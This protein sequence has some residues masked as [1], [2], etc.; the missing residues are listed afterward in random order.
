MRPPPGV[1][2]ESYEHVSLGNNSNWSF[3]FVKQLPGCRNFKDSAWRDILLVCLKYNGSY[4]CISWWKRR[5][6]SLICTL[7]PAYYR[8]LLKFAPAQYTV[9]TFQLHKNDYSHTLLRFNPTVKAKHF[10]FPKLDGIVLWKG[11]VTEEA[12]FSMIYHYIWFL[13]LFFCQIIN[14]WGC[15][16]VR[17]IWSSSLAQT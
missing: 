9:H 7:V 1:W 8:S 11:Y 3:C 17:I 6:I 5:K 15:S 4:F 12:C 10:F 13:W 2:S 16:V 14:G